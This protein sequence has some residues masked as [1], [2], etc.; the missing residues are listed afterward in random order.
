MSGFVTVIGLTMAAAVFSVFMKSANMPVFALLVGLAAGVLVL[1]LLLPKLTEVIGIF[2]QLAA[3]AN[4]NS[5]YLTLVLKIVAICYLAEFMGQICR[6]SGE[7]GLAM[8]IDLGAKITVMVLAV[9]VVVSVLEEIL[10][11][12]P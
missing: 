1:A 12:L 4:L 2:R 5:V 11:I 7:S 3:L 9:P 10:R 8:K 6:D